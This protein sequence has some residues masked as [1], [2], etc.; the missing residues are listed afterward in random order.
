MKNSEDKLIELLKLS[1]KPISSKKLAS[2]LSVSD[3]TVRNYI[4]TL[5]NSGYNIIS[6]EDGYFYNAPINQITTVYNHKDLNSDERVNYLTEKF[7][8][9]KDGINLYDLADSIFVSYS[10]IE[11]DLSKVKKSIESFNLKLIRKDGLIKIEGAEKNKRKSMSKLL[12]DN[13]E[14]MINSTINQLCEM[15]KLSFEQL[16]LITTNALKETSLYASDFA[17]KSILIHIIINLAR[18][19]ISHYTLNKILY[20]P[21]SKFTKEYECASIIY[22]KVNEAINIST[23]EFELEQLAFLINAKTTNMSEDADKNNQPNSFDNEIIAFVNSLIQEVNMLYYIDLNDSDF[24]NFFSMHLSN[25]LFRVKNNIFNANP[26]T[27]RI[28]IQNPLIY[29][30]AVYISQ[31]FAHKYG[32]TFNQ[33]EITFIALHVG[34]VIEKKEDD[35]NMLKCI[36]FMHDYYYF[37]DIQ[38]INIMNTKLLKKCEI[39]TVTNNQNNFK[40]YDFDFIINAT[41]STLETNKPYIYVS[42]ILNK[43]DY[44][45]IIDFSDSLN[46]NRQKKEF[47]K[48]LLSF[49]DDR[50]FEKNHYEKTPEEMIKYLSKKLINIGYATK[51]FT[52]S[53]LERELATST[54]FDNKIAIPHSILSSTTKNCGA[55][56]INEKAMKWGNFN[57]NIIILIGINHN[58]RKEFKEIYKT[59]LD[60]FDQ[61]NNIDKLIHVNSIFE[62]IDT[63]TNN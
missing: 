44:K 31:K 42:S 29:D 63:L 61:Q 21:Q 23:N 36:L 50:L 58:E 60:F 18:I 52:D 20:S 38:K 8:M 55:I 54:G 48:R 9:S 26:L 3:R 19:G 15:L 39:I 62:F 12:S 46:A 5:R 6:S 56:I 32:Y 7:I 43:K 49:F 16:Q 57:V 51:D 41:T 24:I 40:D 33:D 11:K 28:Y 25:A 13:K 17:L 47:K 34:A 53:V 35:K 1:T 2:L 10:T 14:T 30:I 27:N 4:K 37:K 45:N 59:L 22:S